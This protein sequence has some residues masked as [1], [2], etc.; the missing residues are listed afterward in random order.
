MKISVGW[1]LGPTLAFA[2]CLS[3]AE[4]ELPA[5]IKNAFNLKQYIDYVQID[6][7][8]YV[9]VAGG[10][11]GEFAGVKTTIIGKKVP[12]P[13]FVAKISPTGQEILRVTEIGPSGEATSAGLELR[14]MIVELDG[15]VVLAGTAYT[16][17]LA[18]TEG[19][20]QPKAEKGG[21]FLLKLD[22]AGEKL[23]F[24]TY[25]GDSTATR[26]ITLAA[27]RE[28]AYVIGGVTDGKAFPTTP[29]ALHRSVPVG[30]GQVG[31]VSKIS[32]DGKQLLASTFIADG[33]VGA[34]AIDSS[35]AI[36]L[37][38]GR[39][40]S[41]LNPSVSQL[42]ISKPLSADCP[43]YYGYGGRSMAIDQENS[44]YVVCSGFGSGL[45]MIT[46][47]DAAGSIVWNKSFNNVRLDALV[48]ARDRM[49]WA[50]GGAYRADVPT[51]DTLQPCNMNLPHEQTPP[52]WQV[53]TGLFMVLGSEG[54]VTF[55]TLLGGAPPAGIGDGN[56]I[57]AL[58]EAPDGS[59]YLVGSTNSREFPG[60]AELASDPGSSPAAKNFGFRLDLAS[61]PRDRL[62]LACLGVQFPY[63]Q[64]V[65]APVVPATFMRVFGSGFGPLEPVSGE[66]GADGAFPLE[67][68]GVRITVNDIA[69]PILHVQERQI[70][71]MVPKAVVGP[72]AE[73]CVSRDHT[74]ACLFSYVGQY[75]PVISPLVLNEDGTVNSRDNPAVG[76]S[77]ISLFGFGFGAFDPETPD[78]ALTSAAL[79]S[80]KSPVALY[81][82]RLQ[83]Y[84]APIYTGTAPGLVNGANQVNVRVTGGSG[85]AGL[86][87]IYTGGLD[88]VPQRWASQGFSIYIK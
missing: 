77:I 30:S 67:L 86:S 33:S 22:P 68:A 25:I 51:R 54:N 27:D 65:E 79:P 17:D 70:G 48:A 64:A 58:A 9:Y 83:R 42:L 60:G 85:P 63:G 44:T 19:S 81:F 43:T 18:T 32:A 37:A 74:R 84:A 15:S 29:G 66:L 14:G 24:S 6:R 71:F 62:A 1:V 3:A 4:L 76:G 28:G 41:A 36:R 13:L 52:L 12:F 26:G 2:Y 21:A 80:F 59:P 40:Y 20:F 69:A 45:A 50:A 47:Y 57:S 87:V 11:R 46:K 10:A 16:P 8:G 34:M 38:T 35:G 56:S 88:T 78:G 31:F 49:L 23:A 73:V 72:T 82:G 55:S 5:A 39:S 61:I 75:S 7:S 53:S